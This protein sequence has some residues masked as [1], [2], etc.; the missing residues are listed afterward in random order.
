MPFRDF[1]LAEAIAPNRFH[2]ILLPTERC[3][4]RCTYCYEDF[5]V[6][7]MQPPLVNGVKRLISNRIPHLQFLVLSWFGGEPLLALDTVLDIGTHA[8]KLCMAHGARFSANTTT[9]GYLLTADLLAQ[10]LSISHREHQIT[11]DGDEEWHDRT[12]VLANHKPT[13]SKIWSNLVSYKKVAGDWQ[14]LLRL[15]VHGDNIESVKRL[16]KQVTR[17]LLDDPRFSVFF[18]KISLLGNMPIK[19]KIL[20]Q[21]R[22]LEALAYITDGS[23]VSRAANSGISEEHLEGYICYAAKPNTLMI[24]ANGR[25]GKCTVALYDDRNDIGR[26]KEDG[27]LEISNEKLRIWMEGL[28]TLSE[29]TLSC[30]AS[31]LG[32]SPPRVTELPIKFMGS[33][34]R[35]FR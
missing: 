35:T 10:L 20:D 12:R 8:H 21:R 28:A 34:P 31:T 4:F 23:S 17:E 25:L 32:R 22:Y 15:H 26:L 33:T 9:N 5:S 14:V 19:E 27:T 13:F 6:G 18:H 29:A 11:L 7:R 1:T 30:P 16:H 2:L 3:N 24:R